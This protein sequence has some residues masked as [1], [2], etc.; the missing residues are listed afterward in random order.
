M[1]ATDF[2]AAT[3]ILQDMYKGFQNQIEREVSPLWKLMSPNSDKVVGQKVKFSAQCENPQGFGARTLASQVLPASVPGKYIELE[4]NTG[5]MYLVL[6]FDRKM[7]IAAGTSPEGRRAYVNYL[8][9]ELKGGKVTVVDNLSRML[10][11]KKTGFLCTCG[12]TAA[13]LVLQLEASAN[14][15]HFVEGQHIDIV[16]TATGVAIARGTDRVIQ[17]VDVDNATVT[18]DAAGLAPTTD[19]TMSVVRQGSYNAEMTGLASIVSD[20]EDIYN[21]VTATTRRWKA[22]VYTAQG[23]F[24]I[25]KVIKNGIDAKIKSG[26]KVNLIASNSDLQAQYWYQL[27]G[28]RTFNVAN[29]PVPVEKLSSGFYALEVVMNGKACKWIADDE[30]PSGTLYGLAMDYLGIQHLEPMKFMDERGE[31]LMSNAP[32]ASGTATMKA[33]LEYYPEM[34][35]TKRNPHF[36]MTGITDIAGW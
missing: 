8:E 27:T 1:G 24:D 29:A 26:D 3:G 17:S 2:S 25:K 4:I 13:S 11:G 22:N 9:N 31:I 36:V 16:T 12:V 21:V 15:E 5:R 28:T 35:C 18:L 19:D 10:F 20:T 14:M 7:L 23:A 34:T 33:V 32:G 30:C 6:E